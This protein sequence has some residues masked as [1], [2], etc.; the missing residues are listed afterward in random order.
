MKGFRFESEGGLVALTGRARFVPQR[1]VDGRSLR[2]SPWR[3][4]ASKRQPINGAQS[5]M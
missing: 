1:F 3:Q 5:L 4:K 2:V